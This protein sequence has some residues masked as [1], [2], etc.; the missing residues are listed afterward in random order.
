MSL[1]LAL[2]L[3]AQDPHPLKHRVLRT[4]DTWICEDDPAGKSFLAEYKDLV[5]W[6]SKN[7]FTA[8]VVW[9]FVDA[10][11]GGEAAAK[12]LAR[13]AKSKGVALLPGVSAPAQ[14]CYAK[15]ENRESLRKS[16]EWLLDAFDVDGVHLEAAAEGLPCGCADHLSV[17]GPIVA[18][19]LR[20]RRKDPLLIYAAGRPLWWERKKAATDLLSL[21]PEACVA[22]WDLELALSDA[23]SPVKHNLARLSGG[24]WSYHLKRRAPERS[25]FAQSR[26][27]NPRLE[28]IR[29][30][31][32]NVRK[33]SFEGFVAGVGGSPK[34]PDAELAYLAY[35]DFTRDPAL[36]MDAFFKKHVPRLYGDA[37]AEDVVKLL[38]AQPALHEKAAPFWRA[39]E[40]T[41]PEGGAK[42]LAAGLAAQLALAKSAAMK[43]SAD[44]KRRLDAVSRILDEYRV[45]C[46][47]AAAGI[48]DKAKLAEAYEKAGLPDD[49]YGY[50]KWK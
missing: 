41:W 42:E 49:L 3:T 39:Y 11:H 24:G 46:E 9:G 25:A 2:V 1:L 29:L 12:D 48:S 13:Y 34:N 30:F 18:D 50:K 40:G 28:E 7:D 32:G 19:V 23:P 4:W 16:M 44:G 15:P 31:A 33:M 26:C 5:D 45:I 47:A 6:M 43:A 36:T 35:I 8:L 10:R 27:W 37:A 14:I 20:P 38:L 17:C 21:L 22:E